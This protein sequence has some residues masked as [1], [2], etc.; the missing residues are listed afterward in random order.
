MSDKQLMSMGNKYRIDSPWRFFLYHQIPKER[1]LQET[2]YW[3]KDK[4]VFIGTNK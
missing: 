2:V 4:D 1:K 3:P